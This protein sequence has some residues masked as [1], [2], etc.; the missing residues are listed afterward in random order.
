MNP[1]KH[2]HNLIYVWIPF[3]LARSKYGLGIDNVLRFEVVLA[4]GSK[5]RKGPI[6]H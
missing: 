2:A 6:T 5:V 1:L 3:F 4:D